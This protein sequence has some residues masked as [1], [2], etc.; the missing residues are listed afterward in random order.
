MSENCTSV[1]I[2]IRNFSKFSEKIEKLENKYEERKMLDVIKLFLETCH[3]AAIEVCNPSKLSFITTGDGMIVLFKD[4]DAHAIH[5]FIYSIYIRHLLISFFNNKDKYNFGG[6][7]GYGIGIASGKL[8]E[9]K[10]DDRLLIENDFL[11]CAINQSARLE[12]LTKSFDSEVLY[13]S[14]T[15][16]AVITAVAFEDLQNMNFYSYED[17]VRCCRKYEDSLEI[18]KAK[19]LWSKMEELNR[20]IFVRFISKYYLQGMEREFI[21]YRFSRILQECLGHKTASILKRY[22]EPDKNNSKGL[23]LFFNYLRDGKA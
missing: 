22:I 9:Y 5:G 20:M 7:L 12:K 10:F 23:L 18:G 2:D 4:S 16:W 8:T 17:L 1:C 13:D 19:N 6:D 3:N 21:L 15:V 11:S 14:S